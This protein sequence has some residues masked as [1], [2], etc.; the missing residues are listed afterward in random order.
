VAD[1]PT[2]QDAYR[3]IARLDDVDS[4]NGADLLRRIPATN[5]PAGAGRGPEVPAAQGRALRRGP[6][7]RKQAWRFARPIDACGC[8]SVPP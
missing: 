4:A 6:V 1:L 7:R 3:S 8:L 2:P 5:D